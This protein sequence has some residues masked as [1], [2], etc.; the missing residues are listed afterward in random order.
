MVLYCIN[1]R[2][3]RKAPNA[4]KAQHQFFKSW[5]RSG[6]RSLSVLYSSNLKFLKFF[7]HK[8]GLVE[9]ILLDMAAFLLNNLS[10][11][12]RKASEGPGNNRGR[13]GE[14]L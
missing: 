9:L 14:G 8:E 13:G 7:T 4:R 2:R 5:L 6:F 3:H 10:E 11:A 12:T 1:F